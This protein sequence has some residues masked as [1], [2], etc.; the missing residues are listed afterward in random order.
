MDSR[1]FI[2]FGTPHLT[3]LVVT[4]SAAVGVIILAR[5]NAPNK[6]KR[7]VEVG[8]GPSG[9]TLIQLES[10]SYD[11]SEALSIGLSPGDPVI[12][13]GGARGITAEAALALAAN[14]QPALLLL[15]RSPAPQPEPVSDS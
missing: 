13:T 4:A 6:I 1:E 14:A 2:T 12:V 7:P 15:G 11:N 8:L 5:S 10:L 9:R 3:A